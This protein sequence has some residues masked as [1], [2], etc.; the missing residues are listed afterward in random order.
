MRK[1]IRVDA[2]D[3][4]TIDIE[5]S[6]GSIILLDMKPKQ[7]DP[8]YAGLWADDLIIHP[9]TDGFRVFWGDSPNGVSISLES[10]FEMLA[11]K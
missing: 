7:N 11:Q 9:K 8:A 1:I 10:I 6:N 3:G 2:L 5:L 4:E